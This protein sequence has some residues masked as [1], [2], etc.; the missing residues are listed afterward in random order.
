VSTLEDRIEADLALAR[1]NEL[2]GGLEVLAAEHPFRER[3]HAQLMLALYRSGRLAE[4]P[5]AYQTTRRR[6]VSEL[7]IEPGPAL[8]ELQQAILRQDYATTPTL[9]TMS[10]TSEA[11]EP[12]GDRNLA[13]P[14]RASARKRRQSRPDRRLLGVAAL[15]GLALGVAFALRGRCTR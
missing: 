8:Q 1:H 5:E 10:E 4:A 2:V 14:L 11:A 9:G 3:L 12:S 13:P 7:G 6:L 15:A